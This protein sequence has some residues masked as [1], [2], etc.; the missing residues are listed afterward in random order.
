ME[1][2][3]QTITAILLSDKETPEVVNRAV[4]VV[5]SELRKIASRLLRGERQDHSLV[6]SEL[7]HEAYLR[8][9]GL[10]RVQFTDRGHFFGTAAATM[11][12]ILVEHERRRRAEKRIPP[13][14][15]RSL[16][17]ADGA[18][19]LPP[20][21]DVL[22]LDEGLRKLKELNARQAQLVELRYFGGLSESEVAELLDTSRRSV[23][24]EMRVAKLWLRDQMRG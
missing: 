24:R 18:A 8:L 7:L 22:L 23:S 10:E 20:S 4:S 9:F 19:L 2:D 15:K 5:Y 21:I 11:R 6:T 13:H 1:T 12:R 16:S 14:A 3:P 17:H